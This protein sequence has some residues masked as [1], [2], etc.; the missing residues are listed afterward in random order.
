MERFMEASRSARICN[1]QGL[2]ARPCHALVSLALGYECDVRVVH[3][4][5]SVNGK[6]ILELMT[7]QAPC[8]SVLEFRARG[9]G[10]E[11]LVEKLA[12]LVEAGFGE[13][14]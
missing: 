11:E 14:A 4:S 13:T 10:A 7:L 12:G 1:S 9:N 3:D 5:R 2:H 6:S 8:D